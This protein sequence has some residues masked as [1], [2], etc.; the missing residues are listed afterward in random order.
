M[1]LMILSTPSEIGSWYINTYTPKTGEG[2]QRLEGELATTEEEKK[3]RSRS[4]TLSGVLKRGEVIH[5]MTRVQCKFW[6]DRICKSVDV[7]LWCRP[8]EKEREKW[9]HFFLSF[10]FPFNI[11]CGWSNELTNDTPIPTPLTP[12]TGPDFIVYHTLWNTMCQENSSN[13]SSPRSFS[14][15]RF[16]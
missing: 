2:K 12:G 9:L 5:H 3:I 6:E 13:S 16:E 14:S 10:F 11:I 4:R 8:K 1:R 15:N 7:S